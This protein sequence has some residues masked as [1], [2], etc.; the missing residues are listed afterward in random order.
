[1]DQR[2]QLE[3]VY[4]LQFPDSLFAFWE[5]VQTYSSQFAILEMSLLGPFD[6]LRGSPAEVNPLW[7]ARYYNDPPEFLTLASGH[8][9]GLHWGYYVDDPLK[10]AFPVASFYSNDAFQLTVKG[11]SLFEAVRYEIE[12][13]YR[14]SMDYMESDPDYKQSYEEKI[15]QLAVLREALQKYETGERPEVGNRYLRTRANSRRRLPPT[16]DD[17]GIKVPEGSYR[18]LK[19]ADSFQIWNYVPNEK[20]VQ[21]KAAEA[22]DLLTQGYPGAALKLGKDLWI[23]RDF[24]ETSYALL[25]AAYTAL[26][27]D[28]L[29]EWLK[30]AIAY[31][32]ACD[33][34]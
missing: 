4:G 8:T 31:R 30:V 28:Q 24:R 9:D 12:I 20:D 14:D 17:M 11:K 6:I 32:K 34:K 29:K 15:S 18:P 1:M 23:Y 2:A 33:T 22:M 26:N 10:P 21:E 7:D 5:F 13:S 16:R 19:G 27:R 3:Q 25:D